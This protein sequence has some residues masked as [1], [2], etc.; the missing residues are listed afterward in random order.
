VGFV[1]G[2]T[3]GW[4]RDG[5]RLATMPQMTNTELAELL[6][7]AKEPVTV[8]DVREPGEVESGAI[9]NAVTIP[10]GKLEKN[11]AA[12]D[13]DDL[14]VV[15]CRTGYRSSIASS[16]LRRA[17]FRGVANL[18]GGFDGWKAAGLPTSIPTVAHA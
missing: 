15:M 11:L 14:I 13:R 3:A 10:L 2:G 1:D 7:E 18:T 5:R 12:L 4:E 16:I 6:S 8:L 17:G 9:E